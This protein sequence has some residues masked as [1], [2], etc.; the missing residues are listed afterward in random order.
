M[1]TVDFHSWSLDSMNSQ[2]S[3]K[4]WLMCR[5]VARLWLR[6]QGV[7]IFIIFLAQS[8]HPLS[9]FKRTSSNRQRK[10]YSAFKK[11]Y[12]I[13][14]R[15]SGLKKLWERTHS[16]KIHSHLSPFTYF[17]YAVKKFTVLYVFIH[18]ISFSGHVSFTHLIYF[19]CQSRVEL[20]I[21]ISTYP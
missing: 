19:S 17:I 18:F 12:L 4:C 2:F 16:M 1:S 7:F 13:G 9:Y 14:F 8:Q 11:K 5:V 6:A 21:Y 3:A 10:K 15:L 20:C